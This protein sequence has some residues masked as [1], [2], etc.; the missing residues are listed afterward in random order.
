[1]KTLLQV[2]VGSGLLLAS[3][4]PSTIAPAPVSSGY[5]TALPIFLSTPA[6]ARVAKPGVTS[7]GLKADSIGLG[8]EVTDGPLGFELKVPPRSGVFARGSYIQDRL[9]ASLSLGWET[10]NRYGSYPNYTYQVVNGGGMG[11]DLGYFFQIP[12]ETAQGYAGPR[13]YTYFSC[14]SVDNGPLACVGPR[15]NPGATIGVNLKL[16]D[17]FTISPEISALLLPPDEFYSAPRGVTL[18]SVSLSYRF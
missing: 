16:G 17:R 11:L 18:F 12:L 7:L 3:C 13:L 14:E 15:F 9:M 1:M 10:Y 8:F 4:A 5:S 2:L 6:S